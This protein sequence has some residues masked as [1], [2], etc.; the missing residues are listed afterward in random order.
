[1]K[2][3]WIVALSVLAVMGCAENTAGL[4]VD[5]QSQRVIFNDSVLGGQIDIEQIDT[6]EVNGHARAI[7]MLT[8]KSSGNQ[9]IQYR[10]YWYDDKGLE[11]NTKLSPWKQKIVRGY[12]TISIS[13]VSVNPNAT[14]YRVQIRK[15]D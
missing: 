9:N 4:S 10:F 8:S 14:N 2:K 15:A 6:D 7:V 12:E 11:V 3:I 1:M 13:E 5:G